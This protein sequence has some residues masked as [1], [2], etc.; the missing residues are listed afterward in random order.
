ME[1]FLTCLALSSYLKNNFLNELTGNFFEEASLNAILKTF[2]SEIELHDIR[3]VIRELPNIL[4][5]K[6]SAVEDIR[7]ICINLIPQVMEVMRQAGVHLW[8]EYRELD[9]LL[10]MLTTFDFYKY[11]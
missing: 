2:S 10:N 8:T 11:E 9:Y 1:T 5:L 6:Y 4:R 3:I 7:K